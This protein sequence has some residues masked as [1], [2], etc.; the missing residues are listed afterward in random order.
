VPRVT[1]SFDNGPHPDVTPRVLETLDRYHLR[2]TYFVVGKAI[3]AAEGRA[4]I[5]AAHAQGHWIG[6]HTYRHETPLG[7]L[8]EAAAIDEIAR[9]DGLI[10]EYLHPERLFRPYGQ[11]GVLDRRLLSGAAVEYLQRR[12]A[13]CVIWSAVPRDWLDPDGW[14]ET[15]LRQIGERE[16]SLL[17]L[18][19]T[20][21]G[22]MAH[23][24]RFIEA[25]LNAGVEFRQGFPDDCVLIR[26]GKA[27]RSLDDF[28]TRR[29]SRRPIPKAL[30]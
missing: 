11:G 3:E 30:G 8:E 16:E 9:T 20:A 4:L 6:N 25:A 12:R 5:A 7:R 29:E 18:H 21:T 27:T 22:A 13:T 24:E 1:L 26:N 28:V 23:L 10:G 15:A 2:T 17:V 14:V 19:D